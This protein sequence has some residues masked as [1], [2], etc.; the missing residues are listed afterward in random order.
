MAA[1]PVISDLIP[2]LSDRIDVAK[3]VR[4]G[5]VSVIATTTSLLV[6]GVLVGIL[7]A[8]AACSNVVATAV[9]TAPSFELNRRWVW[10][11]RGHRS[12][13]SELVPFAVLSFAGLA[14]STLAVQL[15]ASATNDWPRLWH[16]IAVEVANIGAFGS[17]WVLQFVLLDRVLFRRRKQANTDGEVPRAEQSSASFVPRGGRD[18]PGGVS[19][20][21]G[22][23]GRGAVR[24]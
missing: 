6:L 21:A 3:L 13:V 17:L 24:V 10:R 11:R 20:G 19:A 14:L 5:A 12:L 22:P 7:A 18:Y 15:A 1:M 4:Y 23:R 8:P 16:T 9:G 2:G